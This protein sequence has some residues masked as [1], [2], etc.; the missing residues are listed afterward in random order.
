MK[1]DL[2]KYDVEIL[3]DK[4]EEKPFGCWIIYMAFAIYLILVIL[5]A[6]IR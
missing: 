2:N 4:P 3:Q 5:G 6:V 1:L